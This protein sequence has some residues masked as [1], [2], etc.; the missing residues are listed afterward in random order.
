MTE[1]RFEGDGPVAR[2]WLSRCEGFEVAGEARGVVEELILDADPFVP[3]HIVVRT[4]S[5]RR[6][7]IAAAAVTSVD[8]S[9]R[10]LVVK[11]RGRREAPR[12]QPSRRSAQQ[13]RH[14]A[15]STL[16][17]YAPVAAGTTRSAM[18]HTRT[19]AAAAASTVRE[20]APVAAGSTRNATARAAA[21][22]K[23]YLLAAWA[24]GARA[25]KAG[26]RYAWRAAEPAAAFLLGSFKLLG[27]EVRSAGRALRASVRRPTAP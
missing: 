15:T 26:A 10:V 19:A 6:K 18:R 4:R 27:L 2:Y 20:Y 1:T 14:A 23:P 16:R 22:G 8:P 3:T 24:A 17:G 9:D 25:V 21:A 11:R 13:V 5:R 7:V 12:S